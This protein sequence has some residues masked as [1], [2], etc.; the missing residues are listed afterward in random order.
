MTKVSP[1]QRAREMAEFVMAMNAN[2]REFSSETLDDLAVLHQRMKLEAETPQMPRAE[3][4][5]ESLAVNEEE[6]VGASCD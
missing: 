6:L 5:E 3:N 4:F 2:N 1:L